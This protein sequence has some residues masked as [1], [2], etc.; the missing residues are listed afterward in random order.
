MAAN[1]AVRLGDASIQVAQQSNWV[2]VVFG[3]GLPSDAV[4]VPHR[5]AKGPRV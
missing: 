2:R 3:D 5:P 1:T 4:D